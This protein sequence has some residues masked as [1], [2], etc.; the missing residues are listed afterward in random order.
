M[1]QREW[2][3]GLWTQSNRFDLPVAFTPIFVHEQVP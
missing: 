3:S 2:I 1:R